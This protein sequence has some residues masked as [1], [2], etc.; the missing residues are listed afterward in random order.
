M[1]LLIVESP[2][3]I[4]KLQ[5]ILGA[6]WKVSASVGHVRDLPRKELGVDIASFLP[7]YHATERGK[8]VLS[9]LKSLVVNSTEIYLATDPD[10]EGEAIAWHLQDALKLKNPKRVSYTSITEKEVL[11]GI[12]RA[13]T[14]D[15]NLVKAQEA[16][17]VLDRLCGYL[18]SNP[19]G[20]IAG[21]RLTA[22]RVQSPAVRLVVE[23]ERAITSF[24]STTHYG[25]EFSFETDFK[26]IWKTENFQ[27]GEEYILDKSLAEKIAN[28]KTF[29]VKEFTET[30]KKQSP[31]APFTTSSLQQ[32]SSNS[33]K[34]SPKHTMELAQKLYENG[35]ITYMRTDSPNLSS[36][37]I[38][39]IFSY[40]DNN[41]L[42]RIEKPRT[43]KSKENSQEAHEAIRPSHIEIEDITGSAEEKALYKLIRLRAL[44]S[45]L[46][47]VVYTVRRVILQT[48][49]EGK[50]VI[51][52]AQGKSLIFQGWKILFDKDQ[53]FCDEE[54]EES[55]NIP[56]LAE[57]SVQTV[58]LANV[59]TKKTKPLARYTQAT[60]IRDLEKRGIG[61]PAT[62]ANILENII[63][64]EY[65]KEVKLKLEA[66]A[67]GEKLIDLLLNNFSFLN[68]DFTKNMED[69][70]DKIA[71]GKL[72]YFSLI[73][74]NYKILITELDKFK[75]AKAIACP[76]CQ[77]Y[78][79]AHKFKAKA[80]DF[81]ACPDCEATFDNKDGKPMAKTPSDK[82]RETEYKCKK[83]QSILYE[84]PTKNGGIWFSCSSYPKCK[85]R[86]WPQDIC[87]GENGKS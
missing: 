2:G 84:R 5:S 17:R 19:L 31:P 47:D 79:L 62:Y 27:N 1:K 63:G 26:A 6:D 87:M 29:R 77:G 55:N 22:G 8:E 36:E 71:D 56:K 60:L 59:Q 74:E 25:V 67:K 38:S 73:S 34:S 58:K 11:D 51:L 30:E 21:E 86:Y 45:Q 78:N 65:I 10:R 12:A 41:N 28:L 61:R 80:Y 39:E 54:E 13:R 7:T 23:R 66:T 52:E 33:L 70:L 15:M 50:E 14:I 18:V 35:H 49:F 48:E 44:A 64:R 53:A 24:T 37:A 57:N 72:D 20:N 3:K 83:C 43:F 9:K 69:G 81:F 82:G 76:N 68:L 46:Q 16:R 42:A 4:K 85:E 75:Q 32:A 40:C